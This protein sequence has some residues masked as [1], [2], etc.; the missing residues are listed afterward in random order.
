MSRSLD[1]I[2]ESSESSSLS[3]R[4]L[5]NA[6]DTRSL[7]RH[8]QANIL[9]IQYSA[10]QIR[11]FFPFNSP[12]NLFMYRPIKRCSLKPSKHTFGN[13]FTLWVFHVPVHI[14]TLLYMLQSDF[15]YLVSQITGNRCKLFLNFEQGLVDFHFNLYDLF[16]RRIRSKPN[17]RHLTAIQ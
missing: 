3:Y 2:L 6:I 4:D 5:S 11:W 14:N 15:N 7:P 8:R 13:R 17:T 16:I 9:F 1:H 10:M 12:N